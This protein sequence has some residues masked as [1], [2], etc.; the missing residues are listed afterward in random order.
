MDDSDFDKALIA[1]A[2]SLAAR[3]G[4]SRLSV[5]AAAHE[6]GL[7]LAR[8]RARFPSRLA[9]ITRFGVLADQAALSDAVDSGPVRD[10]LF[11]TVMRR[12]DVLQSHREGVLAL[13]TYLPTDPPLALLL[14]LSTRRSMRWL[15][16]AAGVG[17]Y[18][19]RGEL[20]AR[21]LLGIWLWT[22]RAW[23]TDESADLTA[24]MAALD[25]ALRRA[26]QVAEWFGEKSEDRAEGAS[27]AKPV[28]LPAPPPEDTAT[29]APT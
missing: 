27:P 25:D 29:A 16:E 8:A 17:A 20:R 6:A 15:L 21:A 12:I 24:T 14:A 2:F 9:I 11:D 23:R 5:A 13:L 7:P 10:R 4:W 1:A 26:E 22:V 28:D 3:S 18:G 19:L